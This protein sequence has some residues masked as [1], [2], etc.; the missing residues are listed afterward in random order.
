MV[1]PWLSIRSQWSPEGQRFI[2]SVSRRVTWIRVDCGQQ[3]YI[4]WMRQATWAVFKQTLSKQQICLLGTSLTQPTWNINSHF[5]LKRRFMPSLSRNTINI[6]APIRRK[7][8]MPAEKPTAQWWAGIDSV[9]LTQR[10]SD[11]SL[12]YANTSLS[13]C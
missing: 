7:Q 13:A 3:L 10:I 2:V 11:A 5:C 9:V 4:K 12:S 8:R 6:P 1:S